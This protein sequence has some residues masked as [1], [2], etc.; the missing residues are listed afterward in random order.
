MCSIDSNDNNTMHT[1]NNT[2]GI[3]MITITTLIRFESQKQL[4]NLPQIPVETP[5]DTPKYL[6]AELGSRHGLAR[7]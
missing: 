3:T 1:N 4:L 6:R 7:P 5:S 2:V